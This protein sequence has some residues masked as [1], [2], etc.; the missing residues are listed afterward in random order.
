MRAR[1]SAFVH[2]GRSLPA[3]YRPPRRARKR[4]RASDGSRVSSCSRC[5][6]ERAST[7]MKDRDTEDRAMVV[8][9]DDP[10]LDPRT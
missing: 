8:S 1:G 10:F 6:R 5:A 4:E 2:G 7:A 9:H 3:A